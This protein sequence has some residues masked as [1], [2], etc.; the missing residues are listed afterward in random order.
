MSTYSFVT[1]CFFS[2]SYFTAS[3][4]L[5]FS[6]FVFVFVFENR[7]VVI[8]VATAAAGVK[9]ALY[10]VPVSSIVLCLADARTVVLFCGCSLHFKDRV[11][12]LSL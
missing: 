7:Y 10:Y 4:E 2:G 5:P 12:K 8:P 11:T 9:N 1:A 6:F 3:C